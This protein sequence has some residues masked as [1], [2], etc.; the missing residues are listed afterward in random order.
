[1]L[2]I[3]L[4]AFLNFFVFLLSHAIFFYF[5][6]P[7]HKALSIF[8]IFFISLVIAILIYSKSNLFV[9]VDKSVRDG[10]PQIYKIFKISVLGLLYSLLFIGYLEFYFTADRSITVRMLNIIQDTNSG[11]I[12]ADEMLA[13]YDLD[14]LI[15]SR[16]DDLEYG[17]YINRT[18]DGGYELTKK[19]KLVSNLYR[20]AFRIL[21]LD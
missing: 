16:F 21:R 18:V 10:F 20:I 14:N 6:Q 13:I 12:N 1:M 3:V 5:A 8:L 17:G 4:I 19:G 11:S 15:L 9:S 2:R 7:E